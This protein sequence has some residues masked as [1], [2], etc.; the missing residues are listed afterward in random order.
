MAVDIMLPLSHRV[1]AGLLTGFRKFIV[2]TCLGA[3]RKWPGAPEQP[4]SSARVKACSVLKPPCILKG[5][6]RRAGLAG[7]ASPSVS[8]LRI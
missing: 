4:V 8:A 7:K 6:R 2:G 1:K 3:L 5:R